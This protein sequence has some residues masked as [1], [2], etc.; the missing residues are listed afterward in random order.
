MNFSIKDFFSECGQ[1][2]RKLQINSHLL[3]IPSMENFTFCTDGI[4]RNIGL[5]VNVVLVVGHFWRISVHLIF[6]QTFG[7]QNKCRKLTNNF[8][9][10]SKNQHVEN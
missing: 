2:R 5:K 3:K 10:K 6:C 9:E 8:I 1:V 4:S 7:V